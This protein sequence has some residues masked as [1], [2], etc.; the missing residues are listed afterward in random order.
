VSRI[1]AGSR[2]GRPITIP[3]SGKTRPTSDRV[4]EALF[5]ALA[6]WAG[7]SD[8]PAE[9]SLAGLS[10]CDLYAGAG[11]VGLEAASRG[12]SPVLLVEADSRT[13]KI[14][15]GNVRQLDLSAQVRTTR[16]ETLVG[17]PADAGFVVVFADPPYDLGSTAVA[18]MVGRVVEHGWLDRGGLVVI[19]RSRRSGEL[20]WPAPLDTRWLRRYGETVLHFAQQGAG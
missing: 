15:T 13:A 10:F 7:T 4:R 11:G 17:Q 20:E 1:I 2:R 16:V 9:E 18:A 6:S 12:A 8:G 14:L 19:E 5:S 3:A